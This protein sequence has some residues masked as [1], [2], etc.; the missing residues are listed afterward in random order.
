MKKKLLL[1]LMLLPS[2]LFAQVNVFKHA[3]D[4]DRDTI[5]YSAVGVAAGATGVE[6]LITLTQS[7]GTAATSSATTFVIT[8]NTTFRISHISFASRGNAVATAQAT[9][10]N[11]RVEP[12]GAC[13]VTSTP[14]ILSARSATPAVASDWDRYTIP[15]DD[16]FEIVGKTSAPA[17]Q[18]CISANATYV[19]N[20]PTWDVNIVGVEY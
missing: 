3:S 12:S 5:T 8:N 6:T 2:I 20:A 4:V 19:T 15:I 14:I 17:R 10:F 9:T 1:A 16:G 13:T 11:L 7:V 18:I